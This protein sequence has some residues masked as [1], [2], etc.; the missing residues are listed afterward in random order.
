MSLAVCHFITNTRLGNIK[1]FNSSSLLTTLLSAPINCDIYTSDIM[2]KGGVCDMNNVTCIIYLRNMRFPCVIKGN[3]LSRSHW[4]SFTCHRIKCFVLKPGCGDC[5]SIYI[6]L[7]A[8]CFIAV[9]S[10]P[11]QLTGEFLLQ[12]M[13]TKC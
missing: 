7:F 6:F 12:S 8:M 3:S 1:L 4:E 10:T 9:N 5:F 2:L 11:S 13:S